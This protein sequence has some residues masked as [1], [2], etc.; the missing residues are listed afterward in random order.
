MKKKVSGLNTDHYIIA[1]VSACLGLICLFLPYAS[2][3]GVRVSLIGMPGKLSLTGSDFIL[4]SVVVFTILSAI[5]AVVGFFKTNAALVKCWQV[6][7]SL[8]VISTTL[9]LFS[10]RTILERAGIYDGFLNSSLRAG[11]WILLIASYVTLVFVMK[12]TGTNVSY[13]ILTILA[14]IWLFPILW[15]VVTAFGKEPGYYA[16][17]F[18]PS[19]VTLK[20]FIDLFMNSQEL[21]FGQWWV[22]TIIVALCSCLINTMIVLMTAYAIGRT[23]F[24]GRRS[25]TKVLMI[26]GMIPG[27]L[28][29]T[30][31]Y[32]IISGA[33]INGSVAILV[34][35]GAAGAALGFRVT[36]DYLDTIPKEIDEAAI[37]EG[38]T[39][40][41]IFTKITLPLSKPVIIY[42]VLG[43][44][45]AACSDYIF[46]S[47]LFKDR[48]MSY[49]AAVG[50][51]QMLD[52]ERID[53]YYGQFA[54]GAL[55]VALPII[56]LFICLQHYFI[57]GVTREVKG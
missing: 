30:A 48:Q 44:F 37:L 34:I 24:P 6:I 33:G 35:V 41:Q 3:D 31:V 22:N 23:R 51:T 16:E 10:S 25:L 53:M 5:L 28:S 26:L 40:F 9:L 2:R 1:L 19:A 8:S 50:L 29:L 52:P 39:R 21:P 43:G 47:L 11:Y 38:A 45:L 32:I 56:I 42:I 14:L 57:D 15:L 36:K 49:T 54:A 18:F 13:I 46:P 12:M 27:F 7:G 55:V 17:H 20:N 4:L